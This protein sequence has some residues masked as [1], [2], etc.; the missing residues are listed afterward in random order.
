MFWF[1]AGIYS[2]RSILQLYPILDEKWKRHRR[3]PTFA[4]FQPR[5]CY[6]DGDETGNSQDEVGEELSLER[7]SSV[8]VSA[9]HSQQ[10]C[11][12]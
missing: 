5:D 1:E 6:G 12:S 9:V 2:G 7:V 11:S 10:T 3:R 4:G 8:S